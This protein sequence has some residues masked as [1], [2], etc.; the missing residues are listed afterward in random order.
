MAMQKEI[1]KGTAASEVEGEG[2]RRG[3]R[4]ERDKAPK[5]RRDVGAKQ[6]SKGRRTKHKRGW[7]H[8]AVR[9]IE[10]WGGGTTADADGEGDMV[11]LFQNDDEQEEEEEEG[12]EGHGRVQD[13]GEK[14][15]EKRKGRR[16]EEEEEVEE[17]VEEE[18][19]DEADQ[20]QAFVGGGAED[21]EEEQ[22]EQEVVVVNT[23]VRHEPA[24]TREARGK[25]RTSRRH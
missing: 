1:L 20:V 13:K 24:R 15:Q 9:T 22:E 2:K 21:E 12:G 16:E 14:A 8:E 23:R 18:E 4:E 3:K 10:R 19:G 25:Q 6:G 17:E 11:Q 5:E 7:K